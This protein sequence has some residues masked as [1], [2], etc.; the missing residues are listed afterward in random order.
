MSDPHLTSTRP[1]RTLGGPV[2]VAAFVGGL[3][4]AAFPLAWP[5]GVLVPA[6]LALL[7]LPGW[8]FV[9]GVTV[10]VGAAWIVS[11]SGVL[12]SERPRVT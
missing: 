8:A 5:V 6:G 11:G 1:S 12:A 7:G 2:A 3:P 10:P 4:F 9:L